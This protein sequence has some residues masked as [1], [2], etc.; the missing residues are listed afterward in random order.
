MRLFLLFV[1]VA[2]L[3]TGAAAPARAQSGA[4]TTTHGTIRWGGY[5]EVPSRSVRKQKV[6]TFSEANMSMDEQVGWFTLRLTG[7][8]VT[9][10]E[11]LNL[12]YEP[13]SAADAKMFDVRK[14]PAGPDPQLSTGTEMKRPVTRLS[15]RPARRNPQSGQPERLVSFDYQYVPDAKGAANRSTGFHT[16][17]SH[18]VLQTGD[19]YKIGVAESGIYKLDKAMLADMGLNVQT[20]NPNNLHI[21]GNSMGILPQASAVERPDDLE[22][23]YILFVGDTSPALDNNEFFLFYSPGAHTW[24]GKDGV[25][26]HRNNIYTDTTYYFVKVDNTAGRRVAPAPAPTAGATPANITTFMY[27]DFYERDMA[28]LLRS[29]RTWVGEG[30][31]PGGQTQTFAFSIPD[32]V[33]NTPVKVT[34]ALMA[35]SNLTSSTFQ[36][37]LNG[38][39]LGTEPLNALTQSAF[40]PIATQATTTRQLA[41]PNP[42]N[43]LR[44]GLTYNS[45]DGSASGYLDYI[46]INALRQLRLV[47]SD[48]QLEFRSLSNIGTGNLNRYTLANSTGAVVWDVTNPRRPASYAPDGSGNFLAPADVQREYVAFLPNGNLTKR[49]RK[50]GSVPNQDLHAITSADLII[51]THPVFQA[52]AQRLANH[53]RTHDNLQAVVVTTPQIYNEYGSGGQDVTAIRDF[54]KQLYDRSPA[55]KQMELLLFGDASFDYKSDPYNDR[56][57]EP[58][59]WKNGAR[60]PFRTDAD[61]DNFNQNYVPTYESRESFA[62]FYGGV[63]YVSDDY[64]ALLD[65]DEGEWFEGNSSE[66]LDLG[67]GR[68]P[69]RTPKG[70]WTDV[71]QASLQARQVV[72]K[73]IAYDSPDSYGKWRNRITL[74]SD[75]GNGDL[76]V[77]AGSEIVANSLKNNYPVYNVHKV[78]LDLYPQVSLSAGQRS[79]DAERAIDQSIEQGSL[80]VNYLGHGGP[81]G[82]ADEQILTNASVLGLRNPNNFTFFTTGTCDFSYFDNPDFTSAGEQALTDNTTGGAIGLFT[83]VR[84]VDAGQNAGLNQAYFNRVLQPVNGKVPSIGTIVMMSKND[85]HGPGFNSDLNSRNY[86]LLADPSMTLAY[87][88]QTVVL[89]SI[90]RRVAGQWQPADTVQALARVRVHGKVLN[91]NAQNTAFTGRAQVTIYDKPTTVMTLGDE[92]ANDPNDGPKPIVIQESV[93]YSGQ[94]N[95]TNGEFS[96]TFVVPK[97]INY[98]VGQGKVSLYASDATRRV[99]A[100]GYQFKQVGGAARGV[101]TDTTPPEIKLYMDSESF[102]FGGLT[103]PNTTLLA[104]LSDSSGINTTGAGIG[105]DITATVDND[106]SKQLVLND[107]YVS[108]VGDFRSGKVNNLFKGLANG[109][110]S[111][112]LK[113]WDTYNN[114]AEKEIEFVVA[115]NEKLALDHVL[116]Y[117]NPFANAT[118]FLF[119]HNQAG[120][121]SGMLDV[122]VQIFT[123][124]GRLVRTLTASVPSTESHQSSITWNGRDEFNDQLARGVYVYRLSVRSATNGTASKYEKL[125]ILN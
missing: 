68:L 17:A 71:S 31:R 21:Y 95:V 46:E 97:D 118:T 120:G 39:A 48:A 28:N 37:T 53:R 47:T 62:P 19:W 59:W 20:L 106:V 52:E 25:F 93:I 2:G 73:I 109:P 13:F 66:L 110:H 122:Q 22:E 96:L 61:F 121:E 102:A 49:P 41:L 34:T 27:R 5:A 98:N 8:A 99:D 57:L 80:I 105:H 7:G 30:F 69:V 75:D 14:L 64:Y 125:V 111:L 100:H 116:N 79:P 56:A 89:D 44:V 88:Q 82:W 58:D 77:G 32:L 45:G 119:D 40:F 117:P 54:V 101:P 6:P 3:M 91:N 104:F 43:E 107:A 92:Q 84:V 29:G 114:S 51:V 87:P 55:G 18:S 113:A 42:G 112:R 76:F 115:T 63:S 10:G 38:T 90:R 12:V 94:A 78:Y 36:L 1:A 67:V 103:G 23:N 81:K 24:E 85:F 70:K 11:L 124:A 4:L 108:N 26:R 16:Y 74:V 86:T 72:D 50:F 123:V 35:S 15:L 65:D 83:T 9:Q 60:V 33:A